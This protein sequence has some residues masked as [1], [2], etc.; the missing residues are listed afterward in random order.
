MLG[1]GGLPMSWKETCA[2]EE[3]LKFV[4]AA[5]PLDES[6]SATCRRFGVSRE[7]GYKWLRRYEALGVE[8][9]KDRPRAPLNP[10]HGLSE[11]VMEACLQVRR[12]HPTWGPLKV[13]AWLERQAPDGGWPAAST[14]GAL[15]DREGLTVKRRL[16]RRGPPG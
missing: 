11:A 10:A 7:T 16:R 6:F 5:G 13:K 9:L 12:R 15:F 2:V 14:I 8:G 1:K 3:R 4:L